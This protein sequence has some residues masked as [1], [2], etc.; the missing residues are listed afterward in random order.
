MEDKTMKTLILFLA[1]AALFLTSCTTSYYSTTK[2]VYDDVY[3]TAKQVQP[4]PTN[5]VIPDNSID[6]TEYEGN[7]TNEGTATTTYEPAYSQTETYTDPNGTTYITNE[8]YS[9]FDYSSRIRRFHQPYCFDN[10]YSD[11]YTDPYFYDPYYSGLSLSLGFSWGWG[12]LGWGWGYPN[13]GY[14]PYWDPWYSWYNPYYSWG[15]PYYGYGSYWQGYW[16][17]YYDGLGGGGYYYDDYASWYFGPRNSHGST[18]SSN[19]RGRSYDGDNQS[20]GNVNP[21]RTGTEQIAI[22]ERTSTTFQPQIGDK[23][24][25]QS[26]NN[27]L[28]RVAANPKNVDNVES[29]NRVNATLN[30]A[31]NNGNPV[32]ENNQIRVSSENNQ[33]SSQK[34][35]YTKP[36]GEQGKSQD[37]QSPIYRYENNNNQPRNQGQQSTVKT[38]RSPQ[39]T[40]P[41]SSQEYNTSRS[42]NVIHYSQPKS[43]NEVAVPQPKNTYDQHISIPK[44]SGQSENSK[45]VQFNNRSYSPPAPSFNR[46]SSPAPSRSGGSYSA[47]S[48][49]SS[50]SVSSPSRSSSGSSG[51][52]N[53]R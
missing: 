32:Q 37:M 12:S 1:L 20:A 14:Y 21:G 30:Q 17:G 48:R 28:P 29:N 10:Y 23:I 34:S 26:P 33:L 22:H 24:S 19:Y 36:S 49:S 42:G 38:Y 2:P 8:Y 3:Y 39:Y 27:N 47:P 53:R 41:K 7:Y 45:P 6:N 31:K 16:D 15:W 5:P 52:G 44:Q 35:S 4:A 40:K 9:N 25:S 43:N 18:N 11:Y 13:Y 51:G 46:S 50:G